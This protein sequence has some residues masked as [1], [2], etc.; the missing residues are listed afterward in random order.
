MEPNQ[1][2]LFEFLGEA[3]PPCPR[4]TF[5][6][7]YNCT[8]KLS[9]PEAT[10]R[11]CRKKSPPPPPPQE[12]IVT[13]K[14]ENKVK[15]RVEPRWLG[16]RQDHFELRGSTISETGYRS[17]FVDIV[18]LDKIQET[19]KQLANQLEDEFFGLK[20]CKVCGKRSRYIKRDLC[21]NCRG[22]WNQKSDK[23]QP[24]GGDPNG[25]S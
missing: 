23:K 13:T 1:A 25:K 15:V 19:A 8:A 6:N 3:T 22:G 21:F 2:S 9:C 24:E 12:F 4:G 5:G 11:L 10:Q 17:C 18:P 20:V 14:R 7:Y 16:G